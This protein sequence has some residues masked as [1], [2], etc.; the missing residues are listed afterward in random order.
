MPDNE[1]L[2]LELEMPADP[3]SYEV[4][5]SCGP[6]HEEEVIRRHTV[7]TPTDALAII[8]GL[9]DTYAGREGVTWNG[10]EINAEGRLYGLAPH[11]LVYVI[12]VKPPFVLA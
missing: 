11:G 8:D 1:Q 6:V 9:R 2:T 12:A 3:E 5:I 10:E 7:K 4:T